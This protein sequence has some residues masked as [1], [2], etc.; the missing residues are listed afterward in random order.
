MCRV[1]NLLSAYTPLPCC[2]TQIQ[3]CDGTLLRWGEYA[4]GPAVHA[5]ILPTLLGIK[6]VMVTVGRATHNR[7]AMADA[8]YSAAPVPQL[9]PC[10][11]DDEHTDTIYVD[12]QHL[13]AARSGGV[14]HML[15]SGQHYMLV[16]PN[17]AQWANTAVCMRR[18]PMTGSVSRERAQADVCRY[19]CTVLLCLRYGCTLLVALVTC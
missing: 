15:L 6:M 1:A 13:A 7:K 4:A 2:S 17:A 5:S 9:T 18:G 3:Y 14:V 8:E 16:Y 10:A 12:D 19:V 11:N